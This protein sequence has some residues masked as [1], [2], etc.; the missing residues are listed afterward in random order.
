MSCGF[1]WN[2]RAIRDIDGLFKERLVIVPADFHGHLV[3]TLGRWNDEL[4]DFMR[5]ELKG[6]VSTH[7]FPGHTVTTFDHNGHGWNI[8]LGLRFDDDAK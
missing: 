7:G 3:A 2:D 1:D 4:K 6:S 8:T 5:S